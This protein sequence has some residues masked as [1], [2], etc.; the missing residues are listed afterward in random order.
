MSTNLLDNST[1]VHLQR[2]VQ[3][4]VLHL[5]GEQS[6]LHLI[7]V[8]EEF[9]DNVVS[10]DIG[11]QL[12][13]VWLNLA[14]E[15]FFLITIGSFELGLNESRSVLITTKFNDVIVDILQIILLVSLQVCSELL[16]KHASHAET[17]VVIFGGT[18]RDDWCR[19]VWRNRHWELLV[20]LSE[21]GGRVIIRLR[22]LSLKLRIV[23]EAL[24]SEVNVLQSAIQLAGSLGESR[25]TRAWPVDLFRG[26]R[27]CPCSRIV[28]RATEA[29]PVVTGRWRNRRSSLTKSRLGEVRLLG[30]GLI[31]VWI[32]GVHVFWCIIPDRD[33]WLGLL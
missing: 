14:E 15:L 30:E 32:E 21:I 27:W 2:Q 29:S 7:A 9:L 17:N 25:V 11:H 22:E 18:S 24:L 4:V 23:H 1:A 12:K 3:D 19:S 8:L 10:K 6:L 33:I 5:L 20:G 28:F 16:E 31:R 13:S 26:H